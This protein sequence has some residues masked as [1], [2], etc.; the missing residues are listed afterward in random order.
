[1]NEVWK[2]IPIVKGYY[3]VS[4]LGRVRSIGRT[5]NAK[6]RTRKT[7]GRI[8]KQ[9]LSSGYAIVTLSVNGLRKSIRVHRLVAEAFI[10]NPIN[11]DAYYQDK[12][13]GQPENDITELIIRKNRHGN[14]G[15]V[16]LYFHKEYTK[17]SSVEEE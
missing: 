14:L 3:Q 8:L 9:S 2:D 11:R 4:N 1:M 7:K 16:K 10:P 12:K 6:Q 17:F 13:E 5:V 15:T